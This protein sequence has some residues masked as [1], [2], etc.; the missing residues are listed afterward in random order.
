MNIFSF[1]LNIYFISYMLQKM[2]VEQRSCLGGCDALLA[3]VLSHRFK[4]NPLTQMAMESQAS[5]PPSGEPAPFKVSYTS[6]SSLFIITRQTN[7]G[8]QS[9]Q[10]NLLTGL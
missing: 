10:K 8:C 1:T 5:P 9:G 6:E 2:G 3:H 7:S 4:A